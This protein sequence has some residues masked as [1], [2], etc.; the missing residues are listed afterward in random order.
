MVEINL[1]LCH[2]DGDV[3]VSVGGWGSWGG[4]QE[5]GGRT[6]FEVAI[7]TRL[8]YPHLAH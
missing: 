5:Q 3:H 7:E 2:R 4:G 6:A 1:A 8:K